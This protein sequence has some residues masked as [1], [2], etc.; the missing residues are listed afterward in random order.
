MYVED[1]GN[2][3]VQSVCLVFGGAG[4]VWEVGSEARR[5]DLGLSQWTS[6]L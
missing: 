3:E 6:S 4:A 5:G 2:D 1:S